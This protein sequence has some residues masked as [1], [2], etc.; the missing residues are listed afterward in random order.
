MKNL[1]DF[2]VDGRT[3]GATIGSKICV[4]DTPNGRGGWTLCTI[5][6]KACGDVGKNGGATIDGKF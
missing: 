5:N 1:V 6:G 3:W 2:F 4:G